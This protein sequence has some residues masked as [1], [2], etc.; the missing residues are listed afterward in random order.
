MKMESASTNMTEDKQQIQ[1][2]YEQINE[3]MVNKDTGTLDTIFEDNHKFVHMSG[4]QQNK[5]EWLEQI[6]NEKMRYFKS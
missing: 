1:A 6:E 2:V 4:Y 5:H 3:A